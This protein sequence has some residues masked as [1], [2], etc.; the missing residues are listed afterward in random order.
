MSREN[1][2]QRVDK[3]RLDNYVEQRDNEYQQGHSRVDGENAMVQGLQDEQL[4]KTVD[5]LLGGYCGGVRP[6]AS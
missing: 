3:I 5:I 4:A 6:P 2:Q 1:S